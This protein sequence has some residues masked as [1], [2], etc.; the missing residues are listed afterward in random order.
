MWAANVEPMPR[1]VFLA[2]TAIRVRNTIFS[3]LQNT[4]FSRFF[5]CLLATTRQKGWKLP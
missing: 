2:M 3:G 5:G 1:L 4:L